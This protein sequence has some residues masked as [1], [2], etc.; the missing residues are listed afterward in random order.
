[1][2]RR[3]GRIKNEDARALVAG[4]VFGE[5][6]SLPKPIAEQFRRTGTS[7]LL[8]ASGMNVALLAGL[9]LGGGRLLGYGPWRVAPWA[10]PA[11]IG[12]AF[13]AGCGPSIT[14]AATGTSLALVA[15]WLGRSSNAWNSLTLSVW[16]LLMWNPR[17]LYDLGFQLSAVAVIGL[18][19]GP[20][21][22]ESW[23]K[24]GESVVLTL[25]ATILTLPLFWHAFGE[26]STT[27]LIANLVLG[28]VVEI[29]F[30][31]GLLLTL[32]PL[33]PLI[34]ITE[35]IAKLSLFLVETFSNLSD[36]LNLVDPGPAGWICVGF[37]IASW[38]VPGS[39]K[40]R[41]GA[42]PLVVLALCLSFHRGHHHVP[43]D[44]LVIRRIGVDKPVYWLSAGSGEFLFLTEAW[45]ELRARKMLVRLGCLHDPTIRLLPKGES[46][47]FRCREFD[48]SQVEYTLPQ[49][50]YAKVTV[51]Q[52]KYS[53]TTWEP[54]S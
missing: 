48:W 26:L 24:V 53:L 44:V 16:A 19:G 41:L 14:R 21:A 46:F 29:L 15:L 5:T 33:Q 12:Y 40:R 28:P 38:L 52:R 39:L 23:G 30:P 43:Q 32:V 9:I 10:L 51:S 37:S 11:V 3:L 4:V 8:A 34:W 54:K 50:T 31:L 45:Q 49:V 20:K 35:I 1:M 42:F 17:T 6:Q 47:Q 22:P 7:H 36:P 13:L 25:S 2:M 18:V 27:L